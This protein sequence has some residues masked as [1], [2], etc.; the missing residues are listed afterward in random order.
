MRDKTAISLLYVIFTATIIQLLLGPHVPV[1]GGGSSGHHEGRPPGQTGGLE[2]Q[3]G[4]R[5]QH[6]LCGTQESHFSTERLHLP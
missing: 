1:S 2:T 6:G 4:T 3:R 5:D